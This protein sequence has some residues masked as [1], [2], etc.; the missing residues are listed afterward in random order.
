[1]LARGIESPADQSIEI[2]K[3][4]RTGHRQSGAQFRMML[5]HFGQHPRAARGHRMPGDQLDAAPSPATASPRALET[6]PV[7]L[8][9]P[10]PI[11]P[12][13]ETP[14]PAPVAPMR[15]QPVTAR[16]KLSPTLTSMMVNA[17]QP[18][19]E[20]LPGDL[21]AGDARY[22]ARE[23]TLRQ[24]LNLTEVERRLKETARRYEVDFH[25][26]DLEGVLRNAG[27]DATHLGSTERYMAAVEKFMG[28]A[29][30]NYRQ[31]STNAP[32]A[33]AWA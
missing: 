12:P 6:R 11:D 27:Y 15:P 25:V 28:E 7:D 9:S 33:R 5:D 24:N 16:E 14:R 19:L 26:S 1:M 20:M 10:E 31:R 30:N 13:Q 29:E 32:N 17:D 21:Q 23:A 22:N 8:P 18:I 4:E 2:T 3:S